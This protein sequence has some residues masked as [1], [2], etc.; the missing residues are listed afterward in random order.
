[1][2]GT[3]R[4]VFERFLKEVPAALKDVSLVL[5]KVSV[6]NRFHRRTMTVSLKGSF[7]CQKVPG[8]CEKASQNRL[9]WFL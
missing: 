6:M 5:E 2:I 3:Q 9:H 1:M 7:S 4:G 8:V